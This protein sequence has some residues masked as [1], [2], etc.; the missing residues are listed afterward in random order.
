MARSSGNAFLINF[1]TWDA[2][3][4]AKVRLVL[5]NNWK[6]LRTASGCCGH[7]GQPGC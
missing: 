1:R 6:K 3:L 7:P 5:A 2:P 4:P